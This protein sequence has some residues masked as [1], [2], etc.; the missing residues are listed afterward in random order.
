MK[1]SWRRTLTTLGLAAAIATVTP[2]C[3]LTA[4]GRVRPAVVVYE[5][6]PPPRPVQ[7]APRS[8][9][10]YIEGRWNWQ[11]GNWV[12]AD[13]HWERDRSGY[14][15]EQGRWERR[16]DA[17]HWVEG[18]WVAGGSAGG[19]VVVRDHRSDPTPDPTPPPSGG[20]VVRDHRTP[21]PPPSGGVVVRDHRQ[22]DYPTEAP[23]PAQAENPGAGQSGYV[24]IAGRWDWRRGDGWVW[25]AGH[26][27][28][29]KAKQMWEPGHWE[30]RGDRY[31][32]VEG[33]WVADTSPTVRD[34]RTGGAKTTPDGRKNEVVPVKRAK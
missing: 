6:P 2:A 12:W 4:T 18:R 27:E 30:Q 3:R 7:V 21:N 14:G 15:W 26:W 25:T 16:G 8:G 5:Q 19:G 1:T 31:I 33:R 11:N 17:W 9:Y 29:A 13:G 28:R 22:N 23:P 20:V 10:I 32:W 34:H 24:W